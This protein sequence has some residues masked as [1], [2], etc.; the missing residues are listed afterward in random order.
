MGGM[1]VSRLIL[2]RLINKRKVSEK[3]RMDLIPDSHAL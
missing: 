1:R 2:R 3:L